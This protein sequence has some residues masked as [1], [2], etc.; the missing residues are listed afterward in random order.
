MKNKSVTEYAHEVI[1]DVKLCICNDYCKYAVDQYIDQDEL[2]DVYCEECP[3][4]RL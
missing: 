2:L 1:E 4:N 3:L